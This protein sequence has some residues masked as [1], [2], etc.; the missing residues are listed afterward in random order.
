[1]VLA[2]PLDRALSVPRTRASRGRTEPRSTAPRPWWQTGVIYQVYPRSFADANGDG[3]GDLAGIHRHLDHLVWLGVD[4]LWLSPFYRSPMADFGYD[5]TDHCAV[6]PLFGSLADA[7]GLIADA[8]ARGLRVLLDFVPNHTSDRHP[9]FVESR[10]GRDS[11]KR[12]WYVWRDPQ[13]DGTPPN[14]WRAAFADVPA[15][16]LDAATGQY[17]LHC[18]LPAQP[19]LDWSEPAVR[20]AMYDVMRFWL[21]RGVDGFRVDVVHLLGKDPALADV[22]A[23]MA[24]LPQVVLNDRP[25]THAILREMRGVVD[26]Y[27]GERILVGEVYLLDTARVATYCGHGDELHLAFNFPPLY[28]PWT[29]EA[30]RRQVQAAAAAFDPLGAWPTWVLS[31]HDNPRQRTRYGGG[32]ARARAAAVLLLTLRGTPFLFQGEELGLEDAVIEPAARR[33]PGGRDGARAPIPWEAAPPHGWTGAAPWLPFEAAAGERSV[34]RQQADPGSILHLYRRLLALRR[35]LPALHAG[36]LGMLPAPEG[37]VGYSR[38]SGDERVLVYVNFTEET[39]HVGPAGGAVLL[40][41]RG[42]DADR[43]FDGTLAAE[44]AVIVLPNSRA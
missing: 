11:A 6:D 34:E 12:R 43:P 38:R 44:E 30:W 1:V 25:E 2:R 4:T 37:V 41:S 8:H 26:G 14:N 27:P 35:R 16:T 33:D 36:M 29:A 24:G 17:Y 40:S 42:P 18:F 9:W 10:A 19:D 39:V 23:A 13:P 5:V 20:A 15:W 21:G 31:N 22:P 32:E 3:I 7:E 28:A